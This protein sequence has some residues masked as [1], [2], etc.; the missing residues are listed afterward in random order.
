VRRIPSGRIAMLV[1][2]VVVLATLMGRQEWRVRGRVAP[3]LARE[4]HHQA[5]AHEKHKMTPLQVRTT[6]EK[7][8]GHHAILTV[9]MTRAQ[10]RDAPDFTQLLR[11]ALGANTGDLSAA[12]A[13][14]HGNKAGETFRRLWTS[15]NIALF[16]YAQA[17]SL[18]RPRGK[19]K[20]IARLDRYRRDFGKFVEQATDAA[21]KAPAVSEALKTHLDHL[22]QQV[23]AYSRRDY[24]EAYRLERQAYA[25]MFPVGKTLA[26]GLT[27]SLPGEFVVP[28]HNAGH[29]LRSALTLLLGEHVEL[30]VDA[31]RAGLRGLPEFKFAAGALNANT[32]DISRAIDALFGRKKARAFSDVWSDHI[33]LFVDYTVA[34]AE[35]NESKQ[36]EARQNLE[37]FPS[38]LARFLSRVTG[39]KR[40][41]VL[42]KELSTHDDLLLRHIDAYADGDYRTA[43]RVSYDA[44]QHMASTAATLATLIEKRARTLA[45]L[46][47]PQTGGGGTR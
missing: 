26:V 11:A 24:G 44:Y 34:T 32:R 12:V 14:L 5:Q 31:T 36:D 3:A 47:G 15:H 13:A 33:E 7:L 45:P 17:E 38:R 20:A 39:F 9:R 35:G 22:I 25:H 1:V 40:P 8:L 43:N 21:L 30:V 2:V 4:S 29:E 27:G 19:K 23:E 18:E 46:G 10:L 6:L 16:R 41:E 37:S 42:D 28:L